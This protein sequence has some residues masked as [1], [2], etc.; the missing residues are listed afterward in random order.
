M[1]YLTSIMQVTARR[2]NLALDDM[3]L[4]TDVTNIRDCTQITVAADNGCYI[5]GFYLQG[6]AWELGRGAEQGNLMDMIPKELYPEMPVVHITAIN[7]KD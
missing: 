2:D 3:T 4:K 5:H 6:A 1:S 7:R